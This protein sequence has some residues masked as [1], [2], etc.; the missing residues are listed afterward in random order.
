MKKRLAQ[1]FRD[2]HAAYT[3][4]YAL[5]PKLRAADPYWQLARAAL[6]ALAD[7]ELRLREG[8]GLVDKKAVASARGKA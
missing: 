8:R 1:P 7:E 4:L 2:L 5:R 6:L 3:L